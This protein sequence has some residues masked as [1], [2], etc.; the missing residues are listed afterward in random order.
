MVRMKI[1]V[2]GGCG[3]IGSHLVEKLIADGNEVEVI[4]NDLRYKNPK[5]KIVN[6]DIVRDS[7]SEYFSGVET[8]FHLAADPF[9]DKSAENPRKSLE[10][11]VVGTFNVLEACRKANVKQIIFTSTSTVYGE[12][13]IM[14]TPEDYPLGPISN[15]GASKVA[16][17]A[18][19]ASYAGSYGIKGTNLRLAN[20]FGPRS[21]HGVL[22]DFFHKLKKDPKKLEILGDGK[23]EKSYLYISD[24]VEAILIAWKKQKKIVDY[25]N[26]GSAEKTT[27]NEV[28]KLVC[29][30]LKISPKFEYAGGRKGWVGDVTEMLLDC[31]KLKKLGWNSRIGLEEGVKK[32]LE[33]IYTTN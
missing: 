18:Y 22:Y 15:Y 20:I 26:V 28:A 12:A 27:T 29:R 25:F 1:L 16:G 23:Q 31:S 21:T 4:D 30:E 32:Y 10:D 2:T 3:F 6:K 14:P 11:N 9:V 8:V 19:I 24:C 5:T 13:K 7:I 33:W 17:E